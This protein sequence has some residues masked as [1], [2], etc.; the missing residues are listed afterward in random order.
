MT[1]STRHDLAV[2]NFLCCLNSLARSYSTVSTISEG[3]VINFRSCFGVTS[4]L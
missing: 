2:I 3:F 1:I 4:T